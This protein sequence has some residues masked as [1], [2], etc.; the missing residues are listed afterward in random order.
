MNGLDDATRGLRRRRRVRDGMRE[1]EAEEHRRRLRRWIGLAAASLSS[2]FLIVMLAMP[3]TDYGLLP[4]GV[5]YADDADAAGAGCAADM[6]WPVRDVDVTAVFDGP[7]QPWLPGHRGVDLEAGTGTELLAPADGVIAFAGRVG[8][9]S[10]VSIRHGT[11]TST[12]EPAVTDLRMGAPVARG[13]PFGETGG[14]SDHCGDSCV[15]WGVKRGSD[16]Y[17]DPQSKTSARKIA[18]KPVA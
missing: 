3:C 11:L 5:A 10:V 16:A 18:L 9:K 8:G 15:H 12:F 2:L 14:A 17:E 6:V 7:V 1:R 4:C 13:E